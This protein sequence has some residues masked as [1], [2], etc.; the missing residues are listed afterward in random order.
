[1]APRSAER[2]IGVIDAVA[3][4]EADLRVGKQRCPLD[5]TSKFKLVERSVL[6]V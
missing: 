1:M 3:L 5:A 2:R 6:I 4:A